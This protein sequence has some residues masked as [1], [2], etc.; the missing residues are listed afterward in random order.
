MSDKRE[1]S[2]ALPGVQEKYLAT[3]AEDGRYIVNDNINLDPIPNWTVVVRDQ[4]MLDA[5]LTAPAVPGPPSIVDRII[6]GRTEE[7]EQEC[8]IRQIAIDSANAIVA[9]S[10]LLVTD[11]MRSLQ[12]RYV[13]GEL[14]IDEVIEETLRRYSACIQRN[15]AAT[16]F[17]KNELFTSED[18][19]TRLDISLADFEA[20]VHRRDLYIVCDADNVLRY[21]SVSANEIARVVAQMK[22]HR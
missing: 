4:A 1:K 9:L 14:T 18:I 17:E 5:A 22:S 11:E 10:G 21:P 15:K 13:R 2:G 19:C 16:I 6:E 8:R 7:Y 20:V 3:L 12:Q